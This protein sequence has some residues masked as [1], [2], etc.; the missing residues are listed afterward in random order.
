VWSMARTRNTKDTPR[1]AFMSVLVSIPVQA[2]ETGARACEED[3]RRWLV[4]LQKT[5][6][7]L[8]RSTILDVFHVLQH[9][10]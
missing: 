1:D 10:E 8:V 7:F 5:R 3:F 2:L 9:L 4:I 6:F